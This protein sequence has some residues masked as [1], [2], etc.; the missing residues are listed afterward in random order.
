MRCL[1]SGAGR[2]IWCWNS[3]STTRC[4]SAGPRQRVQE[5]LAAGGKP[6]P[7][8]TPETLKT[9]LAVY[10]ENTAPLLAFYGKQGKL[11]SVDGMA[12]IETV[13]ASI[14]AE[15]DRVSA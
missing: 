9:R 15:I 7:D 2:S 10:Y 14:A 11:V 5:A 13:T 12:P 8:D 1:P 4:W 3:R 6:R